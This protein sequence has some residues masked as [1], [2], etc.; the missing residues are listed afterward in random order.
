MSL[1]LLVSSLILPVWNWDIFFNSALQ[2]LTRS[3]SIHCPWFVCQQMSKARGFHLKWFC[4]KRA[5]IMSHER[6]KHIASRQTPT[7]NSSKINDVVFFRKTHQWIRCGCLIQD[8]IN[9][10]YSTLGHTM[11]MASGTIQ[12]HSR[13]HFYVGN[14]TISVQSVKPY[15]CQ[16]CN[17]P[18]AAFLWHQYKVSMM[19][20]Y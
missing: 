1:C 15:L 7:P 16:E 17:P 18:Y 13:N 20:P 3:N 12:P 10:P 2:M 11:P 8:L 6:F 5:S 4:P 14:M 9:C 19:R